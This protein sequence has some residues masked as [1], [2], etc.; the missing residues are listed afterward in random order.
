MRGLGIARSRENDIQWTIYKKLLVTSAGVAVTTYIY[1]ITRKDNVDSV[2][3]LP[4]SH[5][6]LTML[7]CNWQKS[8]PLSIAQL[9]I[10]PKFPFPDGGDI[11][12]FYCRLV[13]SPRIHSHYEKIFLSQRLSVGEFPFIMQPTYRSFLYLSSS[14]SHKYFT[15]FTIKYLIRFSSLCKINRTSTI[16]WPQKKGNFNGFQ[17]Y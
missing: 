6:N 8:R 15:F 1:Q 7:T 9:V 14:G 11:T 13:C 10:P 17:I 12:R 4:I 2:F 5:G 16:N 3:F